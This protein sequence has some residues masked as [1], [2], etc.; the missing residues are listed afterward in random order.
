MANSQFVPACIMFIANIVIIN[1]GAAIG[2]WLNGHC[3]L[4]QSSF[5][6]L[7]VLPTNVSKDCKIRGRRNCPHSLLGG[8]KFYLGGSPNFLLALVCNVGGA[9]EVVDV[10]VKGLSTGWIQMTR[11]WGQNWQT[12]GGLEGKSLSFQVTTGDR[13][14]VESLNFVPANWQ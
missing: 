13:R 12:G 3:K 8:I 6:T 4:V 9:G 14:A 5:K 10:K 7:R 1:F 11:N 2:R